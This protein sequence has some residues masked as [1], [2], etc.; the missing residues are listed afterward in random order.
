M[1]IVLHRAKAKT[2]WKLLHCLGTSLHIPTAQLKKNYR[3]D[4]VIFFVLRAVTI[5]D[6]GNH[7]SPKLYI[8]ALSIYCIFAF[9][10]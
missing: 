8:L 10:S 5:R 9:F 3:A 1:K 4:I 2:S 7:G 6:V